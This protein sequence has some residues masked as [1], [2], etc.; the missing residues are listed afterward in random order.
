MGSFKLEKGGSA[1]EQAIGA[2]V[3]LALLGIP[4]ML[5]VMVEAGAAMILL[6][7]VIAIGGQFASS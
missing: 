3:F 7:V 1:K 4:V 6:G 2:G 5:L